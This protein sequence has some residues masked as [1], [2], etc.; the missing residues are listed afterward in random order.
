MCYVKI[1]RHLF[2][3]HLKEFIL[4]WLLTVLLICTKYNDY[5][6][7]IISLQP[8]KAIAL[9]FFLSWIAIFDFHYKLIYNKL[10]LLMFLVGVCFLP[11]DE[12]SIFTASEIVTTMLAGGAMFLMLSLLSRGG[13]GGGD[14]KFAF[15][16]GLWQY[17]ADFIILILLAFWIGG[18]LAVCL[19]LSKNKAPK[20]SIPFGPFLCMG[21]FLTCLFGEELQSLYWS[22]FV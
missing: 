19:L 14:V 5:G 17:G 2:H 4:I 22:L 21:S 16:L 3:A 13:M 11:F 8:M 1:S 15:V 12:M 6:L 20:D 18:F 10:L 9:S 7:P